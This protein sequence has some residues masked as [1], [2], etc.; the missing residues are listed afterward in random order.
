M[1]RTSW[2]SN[3]GFPAGLVSFCPCACYSSFPPSVPERSGK[4][5]RLRQAPFLRLTR[6]VAVPS[7]VSLLHRSA[8]R[9]RMGRLCQ[10]AF[11]GTSTSARLRGPLRASRGDFQQSSTGH[12]TRPGRVS[13]EGL[14][15]QRQTKE[16]DLA[17]AI[18]LVAFIVALY[19]C[20]PLVI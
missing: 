3:A 19:E 11:C 8:V 13:M 7:R 16:D 20:G 18:P 5:L 1:P 4:S 17:V 12:R 14:P 9:N 2:S 6:E 10:T 15:S